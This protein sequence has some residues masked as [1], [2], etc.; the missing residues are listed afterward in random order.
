M[1]PI[2]EAKDLALAAAAHARA[3][4]R[5]IGSGRDMVRAVHLARRH[6]KRARSLLRAL[7]PL[8]REAVARENGFLRAFAHQLAPLR[9]AHALEEAARQVGLAAHGGA[10][11]SGGVDLTALG[12]A[13]QRQARVIARLAP[14][15]AP[16]H[17]L[18]M[19]VARSYRRARR[20]Y[21]RYEL[22]PGTE[23]LHEARKRIKD[24]LH[25]VEALADRR[26]KRA[27]PKP[28]RLDE[29]GEQ[30]GA[31]RD[32]DLLAHRL[33]RKAGNETKLIRIAARQTRLERAVARAGARAFADKPSAVEKAWRGA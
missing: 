17:F 6:I 31:I 3:A 26:P 30:M 29:L 9:D 16:R 14:A 18:A 8:S 4:G 5:L 24:C 19:A 20:A 32:L 7:A 1:R 15:Q 33:R 27:P 13:L 28:G 21:A 12:K 25:L 11:Q 2:G 10:T 22:D 23:P